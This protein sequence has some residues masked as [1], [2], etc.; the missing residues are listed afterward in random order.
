MFT[1]FPE[2]FVVENIISCTIL[3]GLFLKSISKPQTFI[4]ST[5]SIASSTISAKS[6]L[7]EAYVY[8]HFPKHFYK[9]LVAVY[10]LQELQIGLR[11]F[12]RSMHTMKTVA[13]V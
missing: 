11:F 1:D 4:I 3:K 7:D 13:P 5:T 6:T 2:V 8:L 12:T 9:L 10:K